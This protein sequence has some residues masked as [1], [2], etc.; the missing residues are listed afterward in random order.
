MKARL[1]TEEK[2]QGGRGCERRRGGVAG[3]GGG[4]AALVA[5]V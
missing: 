1:T 4:V 5:V 2:R 3:R